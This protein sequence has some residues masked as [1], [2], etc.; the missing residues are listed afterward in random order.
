MPLPL[1]HHDEENP[2]FVPTADPANAPAIDS[3]AE[4]GRLEEPQELGLDFHASPSMA[5]LAQTVK[6][7]LF[8]GL[9]GWTRTWSKRA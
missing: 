1:D 7:G 4:G 5:P 9:S 3:I 2:A 6:A 8:A